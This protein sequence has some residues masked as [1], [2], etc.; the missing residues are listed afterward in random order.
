M[1]GYGSS[2]DGHDIFQPLSSGIK[3]CINTCLESVDSKID[4]INA[5]A[6]GTQIG[7]VEEISAFRDIFST[8]KDSP[9]ISS[10]KS[11]SGHSIGSAGIHELNFFTHHA[12]HTRS[13][14][15]ISVGAFWR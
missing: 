6:A 12:R 13:T 8:G 1:A 2:S 5:H 3:R 10:T 7:D 9:K 14:D 11:L 15:K 4:Y